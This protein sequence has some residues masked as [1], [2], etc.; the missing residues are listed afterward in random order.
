MAATVTK[1]ISYEGHELLASAP[2]HGERFAPALRVASGTGA[3]RRETVVELK[4][5]S[6]K[7]SDDAID[8]AVKAGV[9]WVKAHG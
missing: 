2:A 7:T 6:F 8:Y 3:G 1:T 4:G 5:L 9:S